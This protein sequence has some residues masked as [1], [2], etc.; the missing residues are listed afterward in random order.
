[1][2]EETRMSRW[3]IRAGERGA[4]ASAAHPLNPSSEVK[5][6]TLSRMAGLA[7]CGVN[8]IRIPPGKES[9]VYHEHKTEEE[10]LFVLSG[11]G[12]AEVNDETVEI[13]P[14]DFLGF[15]APGF[16]HH[17]KNPFAEDLVYLTGGERHDAEVAD[18]P[19]LGKRLVRVGEAA[20]LHA[21]DGEAF[22]GVPKL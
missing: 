11:R 2:T 18:F 5:G 10:W 8:L 22:P 1:L 19:R 16:A 3:L 6:F 7:R 17:L 4:E 15:P 12:A 13:G 9:F 14:G 20:A 21:L